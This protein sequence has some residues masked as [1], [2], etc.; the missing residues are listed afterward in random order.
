MSK[1]AIEWTEESWNPIVGCSIKSPGCKH[2]YAMSKARRI[3]AFNDAARAKGNKAPSPQYDGTTHQVNGHPVWTGK[4]AMA[5]DHILLAPLKRKKP[6]TYFVNS[7]GDLFHEDCPDEWIDRVFDVMEH[8]DYWTGSEVPS[9]RHT[10]QILTKR[11]ERMCSYVTARYAKKQH[12][13]DQFKNCPTPEM[14]DSPAARDARMRAQP[15]FWKNIWLGVSAERQI[16]ADERIPLLLQ[17]PAAVRFISAE[18]LL[19]PI[20]LTSIAWGKD[21]VRFPESD[22]I[23]DAFSALHPIEGR[24]L[25]WI[26]TGG[27]SGPGARPMHPDWPR[28]LRDQCEAA[29]MLDRFFFKQWGNWM[30]VPP[31]GSAMRGSNI[32]WPD[33]TIGSGIAQDHG[34]LGTF[35]HNVG[36]HKAGRLLDGIE[37]NGMP[38]QRGITP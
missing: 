35:L 11:A 7:M 4:L 38:P 3:E 30:P 1:T 15:E 16:E 17:T 32:A 9:L 26:I 24:K 37:H 25:D 10:Y 2:C 28:S 33:G 36:K 8:V 12:Y 34:G 29:G 20:D 19:G 13:A 14:R 6:T 22:D 27:E 5:G 18:P 31:D 23:S 21:H